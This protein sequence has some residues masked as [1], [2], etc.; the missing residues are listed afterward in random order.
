MQNY[1]TVY[2]GVNNAKV[3]DYNYYVSK[4][5]EVKTEYG[6]D[7]K[8]VLK[9]FVTIGIKEGRQGSESFN[10]QNYKSRYSDLREKYGNDNES[11]YL[12]YIKTG[13]KRRQGN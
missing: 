10:L 8:A 6:Y 5:P 7:D 2:D 1:A 11:Y 13:Y 4:Y 3:Y 12:H 9:H